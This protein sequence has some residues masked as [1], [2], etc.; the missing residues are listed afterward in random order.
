MLF[1]FSNNTKKYTWVNQQSDNSSRNCPKQTQEHN[2]EPSKDSHKSSSD[3]S[4]TVPDISAHSPNSLGLKCMATSAPN[5]MVFRKILNQ[6][7]EVSLPLG[8]CQNSSIPVLVRSS[9]RDEELC[10]LLRRK[11]TVD[12]QKI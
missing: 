9:Y 6:V 4:K 1:I 10:L 11:S 5:R 3:C 8:F 7:G 12:R 2:S